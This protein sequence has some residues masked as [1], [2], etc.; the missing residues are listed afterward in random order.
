[1]PKNILVIGLNPVWQRIII[2]PT[3][4]IGDV[5]RATN[6]MHCASGKGFN[7][8]KVL[9]QLGADPIL[10]GFAGGDRGVKFIKDL[11]SRKVE[12]VY[13]QTSSITRSCTTIISESPHAVTE[14]IDPS[15]EITNAE[16]LNLKEKIL[17]ISEDCGAILICGTHP[18]GVDV[19][20]YK[21]I[22]APFKDKF[23]MIDAYIDINEA[24]KMNPKMIK[25]NKNEL[26]NLC[27]SSEDNV[28]VNYCFDNFGIE[29]LGVTDGANDAYLY[30]KNE[31]YRY[32]LPVEKVT[33]LNPIG[34]GDTVGAATLQKHLNE[35]MSMHE[36]FRFGLACGLASCERNLPGEFDLN[37][38]LSLVDSISCELVQ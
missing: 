38:A 22:L 5:N 4:T 13:V 18:K 20:F 25:I 21:E 28:S 31:T 36:S 27:G 10:A 24:L 12:S 19:N 30:K 37:K 29:Y 23:T 35:S 15:P 9:K 33:V 8:S 3:F 17:E 7:Y 11:N 6:T 2:L 26:H 16:M 34:A 1:M 32:S 14:V